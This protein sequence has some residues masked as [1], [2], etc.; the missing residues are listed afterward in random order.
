M[1]YYN[2]SFTNTG[3]DQTFIVSDLIDTTKNPIFRGVLNHD[4][5]SPSIECWVGSN[6]TGMVSVQG[7]KGVTLNQEID[8]DNQTF[9]Y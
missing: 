2:F 8:R 7:E 5:T 9:D 4:A 1:A 3:D 6:N